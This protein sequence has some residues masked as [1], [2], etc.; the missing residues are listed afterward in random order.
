LEKKFGVPKTNFALRQLLT[1]NCL[2]EHAPLVDANRGMVSQA[3]HSVI[4]LEKP[5]VF[6][7]D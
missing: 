1:K 5:I 2:Q 4:V 3:E 6:T 7:R